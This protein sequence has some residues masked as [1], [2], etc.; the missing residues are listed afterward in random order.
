[1]TQNLADMTPVEID[2]LLA[3][4]WEKQAAKQFEIIAK[5]KLIEERNE[6]IQLVMEQK[7]DHVKVRRARIKTPADGIQL[8]RRLIMAT[9]EMD[10]LR[11]E[12][13]LLELESFP[14]ESEYTRRGGWTRVFLA[15]S[16]N[17]HA[18]NGTECSTCHNGESRTEFAWLVQYSGKKEA[19]IVADAGERACT[20][21]YK[22]APAADLLRPTKMFTPDEEE[23]RKAREAREAERARKAQEAADKS[24][25]TPEGGPL[26][27]DRS[28]SW[29]I[30]NIRTAE[31]AATDAL[32]DLIFEQRYAADPELDWMYEKTSR[33]QRAMEYARHAWCLIRSIAAKKGLTFQEVFEVHEKKAQAKVRKADRDWA[34]DPRNPNRVK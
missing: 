14:Y 2:T 25:T 30:K 23:A 33:E 18:H 20:T 6:L 15:K 9:E 21:C 10:F 29:K 8:M 31:I 1:M 11:N 16:H 7:L 13:K 24:I 28:N 4:I 5:Q 27:E 19:E 22:S 26:F 34:K 32:K 17:G 12:L 3:P